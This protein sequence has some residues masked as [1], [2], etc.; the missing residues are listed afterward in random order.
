MALQVVVVSGHKRL[1]MSHKLSEFYTDTQSLI[2]TN[3]RV[4]VD[5]R[6]GTV[7]E[8]CLANS[9]IAETYACAETGGILILFDDGVLTLL[10]FGH[11]HEILPA[12]GN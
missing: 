1:L 3:D 11:Y 12:Q 10:P 5:G 9:L 7:H 4:A 8:V 2:S 6:I